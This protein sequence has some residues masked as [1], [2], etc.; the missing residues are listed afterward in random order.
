[1]ITGKLRI[2]K[3]PSDIFR[4]VRGLTKA[5]YHFQAYQNHPV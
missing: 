2:E 3:L 4:Q 1:M 5:A